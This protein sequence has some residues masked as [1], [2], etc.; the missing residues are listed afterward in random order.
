[1]KGRREYPSAIMDALEG[2]KK[3]TGEGMRSRLIVP[4]AT[5]PKS[6]V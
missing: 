3:E 2:L 6:S 5:V 1:M 4:I